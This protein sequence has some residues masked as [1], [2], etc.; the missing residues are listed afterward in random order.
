MFPASTSAFDGQLLAVLVGV[1]GCSGTG[2]WRRFVGQSFLL[3]VN[4]LPA[5]GRLTLRLDSV[6]RLIFVCLVSN[7]AE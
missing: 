3:I 4:G 1:V 7:V 2:T 6:A 5:S